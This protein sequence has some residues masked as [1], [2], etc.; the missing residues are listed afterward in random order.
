MIQIFSLMLAKTPINSGSIQLYGYL[1]A[2]DYMDGLLNY[3]FNRSRDNPV[4]V[5]K[6]SFI[7][8]NGPRRGIVMLS[9]VLMKFDMRIKIGEK[10]EDDIQLIDGITCLDERMSTK[11]FTL[12]FNGRCGSA[13]DM[14]LTL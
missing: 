12:R 14:C 11:P 8:M 9:D 4:I 2:R 3:V 1:A 10:E 7:E 13:V 5:Q 6:G